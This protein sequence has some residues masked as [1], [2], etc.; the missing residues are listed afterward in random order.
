ML[1]LHKYQTELENQ[2]SRVTSDL[3]SIGTYNA[4]TD[5]WEAVPASGEQAEADSNSEAD[6]NEELDERQSTLTA[7]EIE[8]QDIK[9]ALDK[10]KTGSFG[11]CE[12]S[13]LPIEEKRLDA[14]PTARTCIAHMNDE[15]QL[16]L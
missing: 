14:K 6:A 7:L 10:I 13:G 5:N 8:Y 11:I 3:E 9:R 4:N 12:I 16:S 1:N 2:L 15:G